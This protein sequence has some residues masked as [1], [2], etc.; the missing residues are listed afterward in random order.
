MMF[1]PACNSE[2]HVV[3]GRI[4]TAP[5]YTTVDGF[6]MCSACPMVSEIDRHTGVLVDLAA[7]LTLMDL[8]VPFLFDPMF[9]AR[10]IVPRGR[11][12]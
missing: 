7:R 8:R 1:C 12:S 6:V 5:V 11:E 10:V 4:F 2:A 9:N 3:V